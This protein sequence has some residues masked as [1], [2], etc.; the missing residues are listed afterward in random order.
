MPY[1]W[2]KSNQME[3]EWY[4]IFILLLPIASLTSIPIRQR[5]HLDKFVTQEQWVEIV[6][7]AA[8]AAESSGKYEDAIKLYDLGGVRFCS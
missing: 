6:G 2:V 4:I 1:C 3:S 7:L 5:A 8:E